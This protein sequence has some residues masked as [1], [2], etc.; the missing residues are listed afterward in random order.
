VF[1][2][3]ALAFGQQV[4]AVE[5]FSVEKRSSAV[6]TASLL[7]AGQAGE[8]GRQQALLELSPLAL[9]PVTSEGAGSPGRQRLLRAH[10]SIWASRRA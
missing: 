6:S 8:P 5:G 1:V 3:P 7:G 10:A 9:Y 2:R 4:M